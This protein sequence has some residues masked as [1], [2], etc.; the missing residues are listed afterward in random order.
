M[1]GS[2]PI[3]TWI[4][5]LVMAIFVSVL[6]PNT[7]FLGHLCGLAFG[8]GWGLGYLKFLAPPERALRWIEGKLNLLG[9]LP[10]YVSIDQKTYGR[11]GVLPTT[12][13][14]VAT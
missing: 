4:S 1:L 7:S 3:P 6:I 10:H 8:Y 2:T 11:F 9:R 13:Q 12:H 14:K 5:P